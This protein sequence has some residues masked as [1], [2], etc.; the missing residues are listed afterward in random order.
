MV[1]LVRSLHS[2][3]KHRAKVYVGEESFGSMWRSSVH[4]R[5]DIVNGDG[6]QPLFEQEFRPV[7][8]V[9]LDGTLV[10]IQLVQ[11]EVRYRQLVLYLI[12]VFVDPRWG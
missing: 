7:F 6:S 10:D 1:L 3:K 9:F 4:A 2:N 5:K 11:L 8:N 12:S